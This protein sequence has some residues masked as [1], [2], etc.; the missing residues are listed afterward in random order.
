[1]KTSLLSRTL[2]RYG[3]YSKNHPKAA[4]I[5]PI[6]V[7]AV[8]GVGTLLI[9][10]AATPFV[11]LEAETNAQASLVVSDTTASNGKALRFGT[12]GA[13]VTLPPGLTDTAQEADPAWKPDADNP[14]TGVKD[15]SKLKSCAGGDITQGG[16]AAN[17]RIIENCDFQ[18]AVAIRAD[19]VTIR[20][21]RFDKNAN[22][23]L[24]I[25]DEP[26]SADYF[27]GENLDIIGNGSEAQETCVRNWGRNTIIR[28]SEIAHCIDMSKMGGGTYAYNWLHDPTTI[29]PA[30]AW[31]ACDG[32]HSDGLQAQGGMN[33]DLI[34][35]GNNM[36]FSPPV[37]YVG[38]K[39]GS[40]GGFQFGMETDWGTPCMGGVLLQNNWL[41]GYNY[42]WNDGDLGNGVYRFCE[43]G[44]TTQVIGNRFYRQSV[45]YGSTGRAEV[46]RNNV[47]HDSGP[48]TFN[49]QNITVT[50]GQAVNF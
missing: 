25:W 31:P 49:S 32:S 19:Y 36:E 10:Q 47:W 48:T 6:A 26:D 43:P 9:S 13:P 28:Y 1:M 38:G 23:P 34:Y 20:N 45:S 5:L 15:Y 8:L 14:N 11:S 39:W 2:S 42:Y 33:S 40:N 24:T 12:A 46:K 21:S 7:I 18:G 22:Y 4:K 27:V 37:S 50:A 17:P 41:I 30:C 44:D 35:Y 16:T 29:A 3:R